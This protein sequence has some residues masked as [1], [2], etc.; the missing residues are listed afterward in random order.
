MGRLSDKT[1]AAG[2]RIAGG[3]KVAV[4]K[5]VGSKI[6]QADGRIQKIKATLQDVSGAIKGALGNKI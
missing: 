4:G 3:A 5:A 6:I 2:N 1:N